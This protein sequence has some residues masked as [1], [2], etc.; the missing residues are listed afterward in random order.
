MLENALRFVYEHRNIFADSVRRYI[1]SVEPLRYVIIKEISR[2][3]G[4]VH[5]WWWCFLEDRYIIYQFD[6]KPTAD[7]LKEMQQDYLKEV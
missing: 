3:G 2:K 6:H 5:H 1:E 4:D 7:E